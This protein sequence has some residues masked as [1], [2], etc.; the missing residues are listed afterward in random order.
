MPIPTFHEWLQNRSD[1]APNADRL[2]T[3]IAQA[4]AAGVSLDR[5]R[6]VVGFTPETLQDILRSLVATGQVVMLRVNGEMVYRAAG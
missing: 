6:R 1:Q 4:G 3:V 2:A 5:L